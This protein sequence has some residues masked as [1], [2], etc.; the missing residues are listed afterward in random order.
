MGGTVMAVKVG[1][2]DEVAAGQVLAIVEAMKMENEIVSP[3]AGIIHAVPVSPGAAV[4]AGD[5]VVT[6]AR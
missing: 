4:Q 3:R 6:F 5:T 1:P 2:G